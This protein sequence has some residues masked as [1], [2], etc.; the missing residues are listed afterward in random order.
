[1]K[2]NSLKI[3]ILVLIVIVAAHSNNVFASSVS[4]K[5]DS[6]GSI[7]STENAGG[8]SN[9]N[10]PISTPPT[11]T[12]PTSGGSNSQGGN[13][14]GGSGF[15][16]GGVTP[17]NSSTQTTNFVQGGSNNPPTETPKPNAKKF[18]IPQEQNDT[19]NTPEI[20]GS[21]ENPTTTPSQNIDLNKQNTQT[22]ALG[23]TTAGISNWV[24][25]LLLVLVLITIA[26]LFNR[27]NKK[28][29]NKF[30]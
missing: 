9:S 26:Y 12:P 22:A 15:S 29:N 19:T 21:N 3:F 16:S 1:M 18:V 28:E 14:S 7:K 6:S 30:N 5:L 27:L 24:W 2:N 4:G 17:Q 13:T 8:N 10:T 11:S 23:D 25:L 20:I